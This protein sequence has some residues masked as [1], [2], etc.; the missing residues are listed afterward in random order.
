MST[1]FALL[2]GATVFT[3]LD[4]RNAY[5][6][7]RIRAGD[8]WKTPF[9]TPTGHYEYKVMPFGLVNALAVFHSLINDVLR[10]LLNRF[11]FVYL[12]NIL[13]FSKNL[14]EHGLH[15]LLVLQQLMR[16]HLFIKLEKSQFH[17]QEV[18]FLGFI[19]CNGH[20]QMDP[21][22]TKVVKDHLHQEGTMF[23]WLFQFLLKVHTKFQCHCCSTYDS[24]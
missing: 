23:S 21:A 10:D 24:H 1:A 9:N 11:V 19:V 12:D 22:K 18:S 3:K 8:E 7:V 14:Q 20:I 6:L 13:I 15:V 17:V 2:Q 16:N 4:L 5:H